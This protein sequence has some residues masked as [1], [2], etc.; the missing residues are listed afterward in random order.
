M[1]S[2]KETESLHIVAKAGQAMLNM[3]LTSSR[4][5]ASDIRA[6][7]GFAIAGKCIFLY[8]VV[9]VIALSI[10]VIELHRG[11][12][13]LTTMNDDA[14]NYIDSSTLSHATFHSRGKIPEHFA[15][16]GIHH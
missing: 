12:P 16:T 8:L 14:V 4:I 7:G 6:A 15:Y 11:S 10:D 13:S 3:E 9:L 5:S 2:I 1:R